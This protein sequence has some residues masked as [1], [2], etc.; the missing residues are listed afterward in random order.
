[1]ELHPL[2]LDDGCK[3]KVQ[4]V[5]LNVMAFSKLLLLELCTNI[6]MIGGTQ[7]LYLQNC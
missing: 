4:A 3:Y 5:L 6:P 2:I 1:M 7:Y